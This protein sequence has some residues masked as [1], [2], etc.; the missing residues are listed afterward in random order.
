MIIFKVFL[1]QYI[2]VHEWAHNIKKC[3]VMF[4]NVL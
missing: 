1:Q 4:L 2:A 3:T